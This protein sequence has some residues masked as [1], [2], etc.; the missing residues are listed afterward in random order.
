MVDFDGKK[1]LK[2]RGDDFFKGDANN[3]WLEV[4]PEFT[5]RIRGYIG[6]ENYNGIMA[7][8]LKKSP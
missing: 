2:V 4:F 5:Q 8:R 7:R 1:L 6:E 3:P